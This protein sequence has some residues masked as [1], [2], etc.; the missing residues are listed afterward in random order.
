MITI[1]A[2]FTSE[3]LSKAA[4]IVLQSEP[5]E[6]PVDTSADRHALARMLSAR[7]KENCL[8]VFMHKGETL[9]MLD[10]AEMNRNGWYRKE[11]PNV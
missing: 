8:M 10:E 6:F 9:E 2:I 5:T 4:L 11:A 7:L 1:Q 3:Q